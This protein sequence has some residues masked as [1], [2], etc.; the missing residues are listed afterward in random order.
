MEDIVIYRGQPFLPYSVKKDVEIFD[1]TDFGMHP[2]WPSDASWNGF[3]VKLEITHDML[4]LTELG[5]DLEDENNEPLRGPV[6]Y[7]A[8]P[9]F[10]QDPPDD[11]DL[12]GLFNNYYKLRMPLR[13]CGQ[14]LLGDS[15]SVF[16]DRSSVCGDAFVRE[17]EEVIGPSWCYQHKTLHRLTFEHGKLMLEEDIS[18]LNRKYRELVEE[19]HDKKN[20]ELEEERG[21]QSDFMEDEPPF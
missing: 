4:Y 13:F 8:E 12:A 9:I 7:D 2:A 6:L 18:K 5:V 10:R 1:P 14:L 16:W 11:G 20:R 21:S 3:L 17:Y 15:A 19:E